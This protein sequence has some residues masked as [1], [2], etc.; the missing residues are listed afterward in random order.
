MIHVYNYEVVNGERTEKIPYEKVLKDKKELEDLRKHLEEVNHC[1][2]E[3][4]IIGGKKR[5]KQILFTYAEK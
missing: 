1:W 3:N 5:V 2:Q 4:R